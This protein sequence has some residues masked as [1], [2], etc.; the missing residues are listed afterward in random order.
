MGTRM[1]HTAEPKKFDGAGIVLGPNTVSVGRDAS[2][3]P[4]RQTTVSESVSQV[5][6]SLH[7]GR[8][9]ECIALVGPPDRVFIREI[10]R[11]AAGPRG[12]MEVFSDQLA[13]D[14]K[15]DEHSSGTDLGRLNSLICN[16]QISRI[17]LATPANETE[18]LASVVK[19]LEG[20]DVDVDVVLDGI[21]TYPRVDLGGE[22]ICLARVLRRPLT[23]RQASIKSIV[24]RVGALLLLVLLAPLLFCIA[25]MVKLTSD[26]PILF[27]QK[28]FGINNEVFHVFKFR[29]LYHR[30]S[31][32]NAQRPVTRCDDRVTPVGKYLRALS[33]DELPQLLNV[34]KGDMSLVGPRPLPVGLK[35]QGKFCFE[36]PHYRA[37]HRVRPG[38][39]GLAQINGWR[40]EM[41]VPEDLTKRLS[42]DLAYVDNYSLLLDAKIMLVTCFA[43]LR[44]K[45]AY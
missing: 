19:H 13:S 4:R 17:L 18:R 43:L 24:D 33:L 6:S 36:F 21:P 12:R 2:F 26:G 41:K 44:P 8:S 14:D 20:M 3:H 1:T 5:V 32:P 11:P 39:T 31:D 30:Q 38:I 27:R 34:L 29:T 25:L 10:F 7:L 28:R 35:V 22:D 9:Q 23:S 15:M 42:F 45:N 37:R 16:G 40:G